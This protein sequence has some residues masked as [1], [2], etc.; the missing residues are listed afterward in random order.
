[1]NEFVE[2]IYFFAG[3]QRSF[4]PNFLSKGMGLAIENETRAGRQ[5]VIRRFTQAHAD[6]EWQAALWPA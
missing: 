3:A 2:W 4:I 1:M 6:G 5:E